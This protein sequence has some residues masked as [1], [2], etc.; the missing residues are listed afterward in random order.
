MKLL[1]LVFQLH[2][3]RGE[4]WSSGYGWQLKFERSC[5]RIPAFLTLICCK[6]CIVCL[7]KTKNKLKRG[8]LWPIQKQNNYTY[9]VHSLHYL[10]HK[11]KMLWQYRPRSWFLGWREIAVWPDLAKNSPL[12]LNFHVFWVRFEGLLSIWQNVD[13]PLAKTLCYWVNFH[14]C[15]WPKTK[16]T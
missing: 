16:I 13:P 6:N 11:V 10:G 3:P 2:L 12:E 5:V 15:K 14:W 4:P 9:L 7:K 8:W 1:C